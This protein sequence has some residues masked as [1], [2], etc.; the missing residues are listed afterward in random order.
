M[1]KSA[2]TSSQEHTE[3][4][5]ALSRSVPD[6]TGLLIL[7]AVNGTVLA[8]SGDLADDPATAKDVFGMIHDARKAVGATGKNEDLQRINVS[9]GSCV[10]VITADERHIYAVKKNN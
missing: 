10:I 3:V 4:L 9:L 7:N 2:E 1:S 6:Q 8:S 5:T